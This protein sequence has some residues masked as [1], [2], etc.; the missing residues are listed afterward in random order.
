MP[1]NKKIA[2]QRLMYL[3]GRFNR[4]SS[5][6]QRIRIKMNDL[7]ARGKWYIQHHGVYLPS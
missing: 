4:D 1:S 6:S 7:P 5:V 3:K 2:M